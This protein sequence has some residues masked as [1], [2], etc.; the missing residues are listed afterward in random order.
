MTS[1]VVSAFGLET[2]TVPLANLNGEL[3]PLSEAKVPVLDRGYLFGDGVYEVL[4]VYGGR[5]WK[6]DEHFARLTRSLGEVGIRGVDLDR[7]RRRW[8]ETLRAA[9]FREATIYVHVTRGVAPRA[10]AFPASA[11]PTELIWVQEYR[12][13]YGDLRANGAGVV[14]YQK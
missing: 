1:P 9:G 3:M 10:H 12:D 4:R 11:T 14:L 8:R 7:L 2:S 6:E 13:A 5:P